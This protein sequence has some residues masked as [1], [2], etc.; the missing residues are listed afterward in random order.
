MALKHRAFTQQYVR[1]TIVN[2]RT[3]VS[4]H[5][6]G[7]QIQ[8]P[9]NGTQQGNWVRGNHARNAIV[10]LLQGAPLRPTCRWRRRSRR[11][12]KTISPL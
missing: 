6:I 9:I 12:G 1:D 11:P 5:G 10:L 8:L 4:G 2:S 3:I 7:T